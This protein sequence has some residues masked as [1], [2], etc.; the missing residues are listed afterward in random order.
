MKLNKLSKPALI[1]LL[2][3]FTAW[4]LYPLIML[5]N[6]YAINAKEYFYRAVIG[7]SIMI[8]LFGK[9]VFDLFFPMSTSN[10]PLHPQPGHRRAVL[11]RPSYSLALLEWRHR[12][13]SAAAALRCTPLLP[14]TPKCI[15]SCRN[16]VNTSGGNNPGQILYM[17]VEM[18][19]QRIGANKETRR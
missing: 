9:T 7:I 12:V 1:L 14:V 5:D 16:R 15:P 8:I 2:W 17:S 3:A 10:I 19:K 13:E 11:E 6:V 4:L 18:P